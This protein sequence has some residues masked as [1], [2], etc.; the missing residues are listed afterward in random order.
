MLPAQIANTQFA[1]RRF[2]TVVPP[3]VFASSGNVG[4]AALHPPSLA[5]AHTS[6]TMR[7][8]QVTP[9]SPRSLPGPVA[10]GVHGKQSPVVGT[11]SEHASGAGLAASATSGALP[12]TGIAYRSPQPARAT[13]SVEQASRLHPGVASPQGATAPTSQSLAG[14]KKHPASAEV[15]HPHAPAQAFHPPAQAPRPAQAFHRPAQAPQT[16]QAPRPVQAFHPPAQMPHPVQAAMHRTRKRLK[17]AAHRRKLRKAAIRRRL[18]TGRAT[19]TTSARPRARQQCRRSPRPSFVDARQR[20]IERRGINHRSFC[21][22]AANLAR[23]PI[24][25]RRRAPLRG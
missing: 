17:G 19:S 24:R 3:H 14:Q 8:P 7:P 23:S 11:H 21:E 18:T 9:A 15:A 2:A 6:V 20:P 5:M 10:T 12:P 13:T 25:G 4:S 22:S 1:N 16:V